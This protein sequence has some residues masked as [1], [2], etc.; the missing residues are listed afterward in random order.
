MQLESSYMYTVQ[1]GDT[2]ARMRTE[3]MVAVSDNPM[4]D[5]RQIECKCLHILLGTGLV[6]VTEPV[7]VL[8]LASPAILHLYCESPR[9]DCSPTQ[10][11]QWGMRV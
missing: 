3:C 2:R 7:V 1:C 6:K 5:A 4:G 10:K 9:P 11:L 8:F